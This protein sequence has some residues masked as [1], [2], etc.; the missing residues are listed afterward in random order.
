[1]SELQWRTVEDDYR[2]GCEVIIATA[3]YGAEI[4]FWTPR[5]YTLMSEDEQDRMG[6][7]NSDADLIGTDVERNEGENLLYLR[8]GWYRYETEEG[9]SWVERCDVTHWMYQPSP[10]A[11]GWT[12][13]E[14]EHPPE[15]WNEVLIVVDDRGELRTGTG[16]WAHRYS[17]EVDPDD[18][19]YEGSI[20]W[21]V[22]Y[23]KDVTEFAEWNDDQTELYL[24]EGW[25][26]MTTDEGEARVFECNPTRWRYYPKPPGVT[27]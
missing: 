14:N 8:E 25:Y 6:Q 1:M 19:Y 17:R 12:D 2:P 26:Q 7:S 23:A 18:G 22:A 9:R 15:P 20:A 13:A 16:F 5:Y 24:R 3:E 11:D 4:G 10:D 21:A 27:V